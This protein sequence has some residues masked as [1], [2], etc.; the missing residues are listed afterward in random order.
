MPGYIPTIL[1]KFQQKPQ[2][3]A[4]DAPHSFNKHVYVK[5]IQ[6]ANQQSSAP[7]L[8][9]ADTNRVQSINSTFLHYDIAVDP[10]ILPYINNIS[11]FQSV[12]TKD[13][14]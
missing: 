8:N 10:T 12:P 9:S 11:T 3:R 7:K 5:H 6:L 2:A 1:H 4:Q 13:T 14:M